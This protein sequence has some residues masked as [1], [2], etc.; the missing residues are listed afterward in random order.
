RLHREAG[1]ADRHFDD[2][3]VDELGLDYRA[4]AASVG[5]TAIDRS[6]PKTRL[7]QPFSIAR[8]TL[9]AEVDLS[10]GEAGRR[11]HL[12]VW[13]H[14]D[15]PL[16]G[17]APVLLQVHGGAW[18]ISNKQQQGQPLMEHLTARGWVCVAIN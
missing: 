12:D 2:A 10:Y 11:N 9:V 13:K 15:L 6:I 7:L 1:M 18:M 3:L 4:R 5:V 16:D 8:R 17:R 14:P